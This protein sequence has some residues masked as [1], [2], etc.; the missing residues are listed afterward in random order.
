MALYDKRF[1]LLNAGRVDFCLRQCGL[2][3]C[4][5]HNSLLFNECGKAFALF[6]NKNSSA[7]QIHHFPLS[8]EKKVKWKWKWECFFNKVMEMLAM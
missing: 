3:E 4:T 8:I 5:K 7:S 2:R 1:E 6:K